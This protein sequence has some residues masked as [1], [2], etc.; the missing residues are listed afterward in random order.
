M[1]INDSKKICFIHIPKCAGT[2][3]RNMMQ[4]FDDLNGLHSGKVEVHDELG[5]LDYVHIPLP[6]LSEHFPDLYSKVKSY[7]SFAVIRDPYKRFA[8]SITQRLK[9]YHKQKIQDLSNEKIQSEINSCIK[10]L[11]NNQ[12]QSLL[13]AEYIHFQRQ[14]SYVFNGDK[15]VKKLYLMENIKQCEVDISAIF[16]LEHS[17]DEFKKQLHSN[18]TVVYRS[19]VVRACYLTIKPFIVTLIKPIL[20]DYV[21]AKLRNLVYVPRD[22]R[23]N[24]I[25]ESNK[26][27]EFIA[28]YYKE[29]IELYNSLK[30]NSII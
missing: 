9:M 24:K 27:K 30:R 5:L 4:E 15:I 17:N 16:D 14:S 7:H 20:P 12:D 6:I 1:I 21:I 25:F 28:S 11:N 3:I 29:D 13:P 18:K 2:S 22:N 19:S 26:V 23:M 8:S 10:F